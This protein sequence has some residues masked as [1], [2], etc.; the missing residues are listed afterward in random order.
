[1]PSCTPYHTYIHTYIF[2]DVAGAIVT[3]LLRKDPQGFSVYNVC[4]GHKITIK[5]LAEMIKGLWGAGSKSNV[6]F[7]EAR[8]GDIKH[9]ACRP[10]KARDGLGF[11]ASVK[12]E[13]GLK[14]TH[15]WFNEKEK[16]KQN[17][18]ESKA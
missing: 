10:D 13:D 4:T 16:E 2:Q 1:M 18:K 5:Q 7:K 12:V 11:T 17:D 9:S 3:A 14:H 8:D 15:E 6:V